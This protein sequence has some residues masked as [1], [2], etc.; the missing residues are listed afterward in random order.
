MDL[1]IPFFGLQSITAVKSYPSNLTSGYWD[2]LIDSFKTKSMQFNVHSTWYN[3]MYLGC[4]QP[5]LL[6]HYFKNLQDWSNSCLIR[7]TDNNLGF[8]CHAIF[9]HICIMFDYYDEIN[10]LQVLT[11]IIRLQIL[12]GS[13]IW[14]KFVVFH[15]VLKSYALV[16]AGVM[17]LVTVLKIS[18]QS[19]PKL[20][21]VEHHQNVFLQNCK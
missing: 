13:N 7:A 4:G 17:Y 6:K 1:T 10:I 2:F 9:R 21:T 18:T 8:V 16:V 14:R 15:S 12:L 19:M 5:L 20:E 11:C 3:I